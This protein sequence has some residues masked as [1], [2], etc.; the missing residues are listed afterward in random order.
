MTN[1]EL[2]KTGVLKIMLDKDNSHDI[3]EMTVGERLE[4]LEDK[5]DYLDIDDDR[6]EKINNLM[7]EIRKESEESTKEFLFN[8]LMKFID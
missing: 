3:D 1:E 4:E 5:L 8:H 2:E 7:K 6:R